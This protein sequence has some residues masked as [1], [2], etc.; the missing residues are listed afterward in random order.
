MYN[1]YMY[2]YMYI[3]IYIYV[4]ICRDPKCGGW[5]YLSRSM[6]NDRMEILK[7]IFIPGHPSCRCQSEL[8]QCCYNCT[9]L[10][11]NSL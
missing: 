11:V 7:F 9:I 8:R 10:D 1:M 2:M 6:F 5:L 4:Y 3:Y